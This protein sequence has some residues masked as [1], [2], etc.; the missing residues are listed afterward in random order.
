[1]LKNDKLLRYLKDSSKAI[2]VKDFLLL[3]F[4]MKLIYINIQFNLKYLT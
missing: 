1:M 2:N 4:I 3:K